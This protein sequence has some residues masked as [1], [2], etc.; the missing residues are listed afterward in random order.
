MTNEEK[1]V[2]NEAIEEKEQ[3]LDENDLVIIKSE[4]EKNSIANVENVR[5]TSGSKSR[6]IKSI[7]THDD[8]ADVIIPEKVDK[9]PDTNQ[10]IDNQTTH[11]SR[12]TSSKILSRNSSSTSLR[13]KDQD[14][15]RPQS[16]LGGTD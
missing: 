8:D 1:N 7:P 2:E 5:I 9:N 6:E 15:S 4:S 14:N 12:P 11:I 13:K 10:S 3:E 16:R